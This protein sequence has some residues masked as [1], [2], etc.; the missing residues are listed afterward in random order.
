MQPARG[1]QSF[2]GEGLQ[3]SP[4]SVERLSASVASNN[5]LAQKAIVKGRHDISLIQ[6]RVETDAVALGHPK[7]EDAAGRWHELLGRVLG[8]DANLDRMA[9][10]GDVGLTVRERLSASNKKH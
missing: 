5:Q 6:H 8:V 1:R 7:V 10:K 3:R 4:Q 2:N 9:V